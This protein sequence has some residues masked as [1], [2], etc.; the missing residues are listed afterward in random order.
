MYIH[1]HVYVCICMYM[2]IYVKQMYYSYKVSGDGYGCAT[3]NREA[4]GTTSRSKLSLACKSGPVVGRA[5]ISKD[6]LHLGH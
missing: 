4:V 6:R 1:L 5:L 3:P 2:Y